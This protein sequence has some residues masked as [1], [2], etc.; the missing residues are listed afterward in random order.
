MNKFVCIKKEDK[1]EI[2]LG[3]VQ[4]HSDLVLPKETCVGGGFYNVREN[5]RVVILWD[6]S[7]DYGYPE[8]NSVNDIDEDWKGYTFYYL[9]DLFMPLDDCYKIEV[10]F[11]EM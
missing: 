10:N 2:R 8:F 1:V 7:Y 4:N 11:V 6:K 5:E 9:P 3:D